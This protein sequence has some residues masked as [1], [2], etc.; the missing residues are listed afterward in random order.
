V[1]LYKSCTDRGLDGDVSADVGNEEGSTSLQNIVS[2]QSL[3]PSAVSTYGTP[4]ETSL[5]LS[6]TPGIVIET[7]LP[8]PI[9]PRDVGV[10][11]D[12]KWDVIAAHE[13]RFCF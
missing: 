8:S 6:P 5:Q 13:A 9:N 10:P 2:S 12:G 11:S 4:H 7:L 1:I 3:L